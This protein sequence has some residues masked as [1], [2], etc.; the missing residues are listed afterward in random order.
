[1][2]N[3]DITQAPIGLSKATISRVA[4][5]I[6]AS[7]DVTVTAGRE[8][9][10]D[11]VNGELTYDADSLA[12]FSVEAAVA[13]I[14][15]E[16]GH[17]K[18][19]TSIDRG[20]DI[21]R[22]IPQTS[23]SAINMLEDI[24]VDHLTMMEFGNGEKVMGELHAQGCEFARSSIRQRREG[25]TRMSYDANDILMLAYLMHYGG[26][27]DVGLVKALG[28]VQKDQD[29]VRDVHRAI[30]D[31]KP[32]YM[33]TTLEVQR[34]WEE[35]IYPIVRSKSDPKAENE[36]EANRKIENMSDFSDSE[37][38]Q[39]KDKLAELSARERKPYD[40]NTS[41][42]GQALR[43]LSAD[44]VREFNDMLPTTDSR[45][46]QPK[47]AKPL[48]GKDRLEGDKN[49]QDQMANP[50]SGMSL[51]KL[52]GGSPSGD[53]AEAVARSFSKYD[54]SRSASG[55]DVHAIARKVAPLVSTAA[56]QLGRV[57]RD[58]QFDRYAG[59][60]RSGDLKRR[61]LYKVR[62]NDIRLFERKTE[63]K[64]KH[65]A[66]SL[67]VDC[68]GSMHGRQIADAMEATVLLSETL[69]R[70]NLPFEVTFFSDDYARGKEFGDRYDKWDLSRNQGI[71]NGGG[72]NITEP[73]KVCM[74]RL[75]EQGDRR[76][77]RIMILMTDGELDHAEEKLVKG[78]I[79]RAL[80]TS[81]VYGFGIGVDLK[82]IAG[83]N[84][85]RVTDT[86][87]IA[88]E[89]GKILRK[90]IKTG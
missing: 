82:K 4:A 83:E 73:F 84:A 55:T 22:E 41:S 79:D 66:F 56:S 48:R 39:L 6:S 21:Y 25:Q 15:H 30:V 80:G 87:K 46:S 57:L 40:R 12:R 63:R 65:Y 53:R 38:K 43:N 17:L 86:A 18:H 31:G 85:I 60:Y 42:S 76:T 45:M 33:G 72:T 37:I 23:F 10:M 89:F 24:R 16:V 69:T 74:R 5:A 59:R 67:L 32:E 58:N 47:N 36:N 3:K 28:M 70:M 13:L 2:S 29:L 90:H 20:T 9:S 81:L 11:I 19:T 61:G 68:S 78:E 1:M 34:F 88:A 7:F 26:V 64:N 44:S 14:L 35:K 51:N 62:T 49:D 75:A 8:W 54:N 50:K 77:Q 27:L 52:E 71:V